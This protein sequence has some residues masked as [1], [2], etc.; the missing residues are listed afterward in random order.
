[1]KIYAE[2]NDQKL[3][4]SLKSG[5]DTAFNAIFKRHWK[6][7]Y[8]EAYKRL[9]DP[10]QSEEVVQDVFADLWIKREMQKI[11]NLLP[12]L[13]TAVKYQVFMLYKKFQQLPKFEEPL[14][15]FA[16]ASLQADSEFSAKEL[17]GCIDSWL[18]MQPEKRREIFRLRFIEE[19]STKEISEQLHISQKTV[20]ST[21]AIAL[22]SLRECL[23]ITLT[24]SLIFTAYLEATIK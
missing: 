23:G 16:T 13:R 4:S 9:R 19:F 18:E 2:L 21:L 7:L 3:L 5:D 14:D 15:F 12:Y 1:M 10:M 11:E 8:D 20:Q 24:A 17:R 6:T 22:L